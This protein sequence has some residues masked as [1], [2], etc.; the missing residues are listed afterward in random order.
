M[1]RTYPADLRSRV[2]VTPQILR[3]LERTQEVLLGVSLPWSRGACA[4]HV[5][6]CADTWLHQERGPGHRRARPRS[7]TGLNGLER[8]CTGRPG[9]VS[10][11]AF[12]R[13]RCCTRGFLHVCPALGRLNPFH[14]PSALKDLNLLFRSW[15]FSPFSSM[16]TD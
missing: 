7:C 11:S 14:L 5:C 6:A 10:G 15:I 2:C 4:V 9:S 12:C 3:V 13:R 8:L 1:L 16:R